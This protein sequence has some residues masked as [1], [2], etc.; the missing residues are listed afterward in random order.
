M[1]RRVLALELLPFAVASLALLWDALSDRM[2]LELLYPV[3]AL[4]LLAPLALIAVARARRW[5]VSCARGRSC[6]C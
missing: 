3:I 1:P 5:V 4:E 2:A 6:C